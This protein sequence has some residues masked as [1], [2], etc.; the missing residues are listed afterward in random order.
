MPFLSTC[1]GFGCTPAAGNPLVER[2]TKLLNRKCGLKMMD[3]R[4]ET[5][6]VDAPTT[7]TRAV[8][9]RIIVKTIP[10]DS[11]EK[12]TF[13]LAYHLRNDAN[14]NRD[15]ALVKEFLLSEGQTDRQT[16]SL[17]YVDT[18]TDIWSYAQGRIR[19]VNLDEKGQPK[20]KR[21]NL[22]ERGRCAISC[23]FFRCVLASL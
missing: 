18:W 12:R 16:D 21:D 7:T 14:F 15:R 8:W 1:Q 3:S 4:K 22:S 9:K 13:Y 19:E 10:P 20:S 11:P 23:A 17:S 2:S 5:A 6:T